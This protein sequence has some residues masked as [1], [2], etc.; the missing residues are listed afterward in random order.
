[1]RQLRDIG[2]FWEIGQFWDMSARRSKGDCCS[3][4]FS[5][6]LQ[7]VMTPSGFVP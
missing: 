1:M 4:L 3:L 7:H 6:S 2:L 5:N